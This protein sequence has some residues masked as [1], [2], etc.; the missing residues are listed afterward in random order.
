MPGM[1]EPYLREKFGNALDGLATGTGEL[2]ERVRNAMVILVMFAPDEM[3]DK[4]SRDEFA[5]LRYLATEREDEAN[6]GQ[7]T[8]TL[9]QMDTDDVRDLAAIIVRLHDHLLR[10]TDAGYA[11]EQE[12][13]PASD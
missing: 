6:E 1:T 3:P 10:R 13:N 8:A 9:S 12:P 2:W 5:R 7:L 4:Y 11:A